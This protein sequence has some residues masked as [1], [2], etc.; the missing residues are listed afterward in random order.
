M[1]KILK[2]LFGKTIQEI[3]CDAV[4]DSEE[5]TWVLVMVNGHRVF[6]V[7]VANWKALNALAGDDCSCLFIG[8][9]GELVKM[10]VSG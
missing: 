10:E 2:L 1:K 3:E 7:T 5:A 4:A 6:Y 9:R 8:L